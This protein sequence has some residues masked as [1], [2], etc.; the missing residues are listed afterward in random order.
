LTLRQTD[1]AETPGNIDL[2]IVNWRERAFGEP[3]A[4]PTLLRQSGRFCFGIFMM[5]DASM[6][7]RT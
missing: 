2:L 4:R 3:V 6:F 5:R 1:Q 7:N